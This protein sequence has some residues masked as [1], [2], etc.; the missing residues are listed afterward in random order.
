MY[1]FNVV[2]H[3]PAR[4][5]RVSGRKATTGNRFVAFSDLFVGVEH[6]SEGATHGSGGEVLG[7]SDTDTAV[8][9]VG[10]NDFAPGASVSLAGGGGFALVN[11]C[12]AL[13]MVELG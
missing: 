10:G 3:L 2:F 11:V 8:V 6:N 12:N 5:E 7:E 1:G 4:C 9:A 13:S